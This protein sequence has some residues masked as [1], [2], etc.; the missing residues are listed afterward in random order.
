MEDGNSL[1]RGDMPL[2][3]FIKEW[4]VFK[5]KDPIYKFIMSHFGEKIIKP[6]PFTP[7][8]NL[9]SAKEIKARVNIPVFVVGGVTEPK[10]MKEIVE[11]G[12]ADYIS[13]CRALIA[14]PKFPEKVRADSPELSR[15]IHC[16]LCIGYM[17]NK[18]L[19]CY[20]GQRI[21]AE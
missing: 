4:D 2:D 12:S 9:E 18:P 13:L 3:V 10:T 14:D 15:C 16:N 7:A 6:L 21:N 19:R 5:R 11:K 8:Y 20:H 1:A 17:Y